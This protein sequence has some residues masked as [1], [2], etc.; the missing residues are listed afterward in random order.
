MGLEK[1][2]AFLAILFQEH[3]E[4]CNIQKAPAYRLCKTDWNHLKLSNF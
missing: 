2:P 1:K 4:L 3:Q